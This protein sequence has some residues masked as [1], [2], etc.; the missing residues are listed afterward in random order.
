LNAKGAHVL[1]F[2]NGQVVRHVTYF[3][4]ERAPADL[5]LAAD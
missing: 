4:R 1:H 3:D 5:G 2:R